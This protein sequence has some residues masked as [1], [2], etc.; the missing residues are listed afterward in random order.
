EDDE[1]AAGS[2]YAGADRSA[3]A[4]VADP[5]H[6]GPGA[7]R[8]GGRAVGASVVVDEDLGAEGV[9]ADAGQRGVDAALD[10]LR[11]VEAGQEEGDF[12]RLL[13]GHE[14]GP[15]GRRG[16]ADGARLA[17]G[18]ERGRRPRNRLNV[19]RSRAA[20]RRHEARWQGR[21]TPPTAVRPPASTR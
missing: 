14:R 13:V 12:E 21:R 9:L 7:L 6:T 4:A 11:L 17:A 2:A 10:G 15:R 8:E 19:V 3:D 18:R 5:D 20:G 1:P 16:R